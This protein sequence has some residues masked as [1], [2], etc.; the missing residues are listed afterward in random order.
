MSLDSSF[1]PHCVLRYLLPFPLSPWEA[2]GLLSF[3]R[4]VVV[5]RIIETIIETI[6][7][8]P[9]FFLFR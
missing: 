3:C 9:N 6:I 7:E 4:I 1:V 8:I 5:Y 2:F